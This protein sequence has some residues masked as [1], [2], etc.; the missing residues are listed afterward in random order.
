MLT[1]VV[2]IRIIPKALGLPIR[3]HQ[4]TLDLDRRILRDNLMQQQY[5]L[6]GVLREMSFNIRRTLDS[7]VICRKTSMEVCRTLR[8]ETCIILVPEA[9]AGGST[10]VSLSSK[11]VARRVLR[12]SGAPAHSML[13]QN[14]LEV[15]AHGGASSSSE[16][17]L[18][19][20]SDD[21]GDGADAGGSA[22][23]D[24]DAR[25]PLMRV[26]RRKKEQR[27]AA[28]SSSASASA[29]AARGSVNSDDLYTV[30]DQGVQ[31]VTV[32]MNDELIAEILQ[33]E[34]AMLLDQRSVF[35][36]FLYD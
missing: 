24:T 10:S 19:F 1:S 5:K 12:S 32:S 8:M 27:A 23:A 16:E 4:L 18:Y 6:L 7:E 34:S 35:L 28:G 26:G 14:E 9:L 31:P 33:S 30:T 11:Y 17:L 29:T 36:P 3:A 21:E 2:L 20:E 13:A 15:A 25:V 22:V